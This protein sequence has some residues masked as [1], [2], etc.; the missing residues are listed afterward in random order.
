MF[1]LVLSVE[2]LKGFPAK[3]IPTLENLVC[4]NLKT[5]EVRHIEHIQDTLKSKVSFPRRPGW[6]LPSPGDRKHFPAALILLKT[7]CASCEVR[8]I[9]ALVRVKLLEVRL[10][11][12]CGL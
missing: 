8:I 3:N 1:Q 10:C 6:L 11:S 2:K 5:I 12:T 9:P 4:C 7:P